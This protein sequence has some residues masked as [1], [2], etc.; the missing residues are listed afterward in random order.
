MSVPPRT[1]SELRPLVNSLLGAGLS[2]AELNRFVGMAHSIAAVAVRMRLSRATIAARLLPPSTADLAYDCI[3]DLFAR[4][5]DGSLHHL[6]TY[7]AGIG[8]D[9]VGDAELFIHFRR[10][11]FSRV[12]QGVFRMLNEADPVLGR[13]IRNIKLA[14]PSL[15]SFDTVERFGETCLV[16]AGA[17]TLEHLPPADPQMLGAKFAAAV[18]ARTHVP[19][20]L[21]CLAS[22]LREQEEHTRVVP[23]VQAALLFRGLY[24]RDVPAAEA[25]HGTE[26]SLLQHDVR[27]AVDS[28][29]RRLR[30]E[31]GRK[32]ART[33]H[34]PADLIDTYFGAIEGVLEARF[35]GSEGDPDSLFQALADAMPGLSREDY[36]R[37]HRS[38]MEYLARLAHTHV[39]AVLSAAYRANSANGGR[40][41]G[42]TGR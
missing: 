36:Q 12:N 21:A 39:R 11:I 2:P 4:D 30:E 32:Y 25:D 31:V 37:H 26:D 33:K 14:V 20:L 41:R 18:S 16:P 7:F 28:A 29:M 27:A 8:A 6:R 1:L 10:I 15:P 38:R 35:G 23:L 3:A 17:P 34:M 22:Y 19:G 5:E 24:L 40:M 42:D 13:I 9:R